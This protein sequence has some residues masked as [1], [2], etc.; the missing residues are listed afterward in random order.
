LAS[1]R[2]WLKVKPPGP[3]SG[4]QVDSRQMRSVILSTVVHGIFL[5]R[6]RAGPVPYSRVNILVRL[7]SRR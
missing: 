3:T 1:T 4:I 6:Q 2:N 7:G 5:S